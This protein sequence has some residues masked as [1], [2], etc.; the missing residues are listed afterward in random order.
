MCVA[1]INFDDTGR[2][3]TATA[4][5][6]SP[7]GLAGDAWAEDVLGNDFR[8]HCFKTEGIRKYL[9]VGYVSTTTNGGGVTP[10]ELRAQCWSGSPGAYTTRGTSVTKTQDNY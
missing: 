10:Y 8:V 4:V 2:L 5:V 9:M 7:A 6:S 1:L 3:L